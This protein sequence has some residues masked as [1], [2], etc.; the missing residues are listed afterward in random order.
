ML[1]DDTG[2]AQALRA[3][4]L[5]DDAS[6]LFGPLIDANASR[7]LIQETTIIDFKETI[8][9]YFTDDYG[10]GIIRLSIA[11]Y[12]TYGG[13]IVFG[14]KDKTL[15]IIPQDNLL[16]VEALNRVLSDITDCQFEC[17]YRKYSISATDDVQV[18]LVP[19]RP[20]IR[21]ARLR[22]S[23]S[24]YSKG[25]VW[26]RDRH[27]V[28]EAQSRHLP[29]LYGNR[30]TFFSSD[31]RL[32]TPVHR[33]LPPSPSIMEEFIGR[34]EL[35]NHLWEWLI[36]GKTPRLYLSGPGG[37]GKSTLAYEFANS[38]ATSDIPINLQ[39]GQKLDYVIYLSAKETAF[40]INAMKSELFKMKD[41]SNSEQQYQQI[42]FHSGMVSSDDLK[43][44]SPD[45]IETTIDELIENFNGLLIIDDID[46]LSRRSIDTGEEFLFLKSAQSSGSLKVLYTLRFPPSYALN[47]SKEVPALEFSTEYMTFLESCCQQFGVAYPNHTAVVNI[48]EESAGLPLIVETIVALRRTCTSYEEALSSYRQREGDAARQYLYQREYD[49]L[50]SKTKSRQVLA[51]LVKL[52]APATFTTLVSITSST[53]EQVRDS[54]SQIRGI[55]LR[56]I[57]G[58]GGDTLYEVTKPAQYFINKV[59]DLLPYIPALERSVQH[60]K[61]ES[62]RTS[63]HEAAILFKFTKLARERLFNNIIEEAKNI[64]ANDPVMGNP[65]F[66][67]LLG[68]GYAESGGPYAEDAREYFRRAFLL[69]DRDIYMLRSWYHLEMSAP[70][71]TGNAEKLCK[72]VISTS[73]LPPRYKS[74][75]YSKLGRTLEVQARP[76]R[77]TNKDRAIELMKDA[78]VAYLEGAWLSRGISQMDR[79]LQREWLVQAN[80]QF[81]SLIDHDPEPIFDIIDKCLST[82]HD[83]DL[84]AAE[85]LIEPL[86]RLSSTVRQPILGRLN[87]LARR[88]IGRISRKKGL[89]REPGRQYCNDALAEIVSKSN[90]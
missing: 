18:L 58:D 11:F 28:L 21:P 57:E 3:G 59:S 44:K 10:A 20:I 52:N 73:D 64:S 19:P 47:T 82:D 39:N 87:G 50:G 27:E 29:L 62:V 76:H 41:F 45:S 56:A 24:K 34:F 74:E 48:F 60:F 81:F 15:E 68:Q 78:I 13:I 43:Q 90:S 88:S 23:L 37:S 55:F 67:G 8:P 25:T 84:E 86:K 16:N 2:I 35:I 26:V 75:F 22:T 63:P 49:A 4:K 14:V 61:Q 46:A 12:N 89:L 17:H 38:V 7:F 85:T 33:S 71:T 9:K 65:R 72:S 70:H 1:Y 6:Q 83:I 42:L 79:S 51:A 40:D 36:F 5:P 32:S 80:G 31:D 53:P 30:S 54:I 77:F 66:L 69:H